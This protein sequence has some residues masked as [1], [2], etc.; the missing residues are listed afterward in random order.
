MRVTPPRP[1]PLY[2]EFPVAPQGCCERWSVVAQACV[3]S[4][5]YPEEASH[6]L[7]GPSCKLPVFIGNY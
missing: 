7:N 5:Q 2:P 3:K 6:S 4:S 1:G